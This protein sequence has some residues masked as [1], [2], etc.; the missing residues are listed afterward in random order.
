M[1]EVHEGCL[2][3]VLILLSK[4]RSSSWLLHRDSTEYRGSHRFAEMMESV[5][6]PQERQRVMSH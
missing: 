6:T 1:V 2:Y 5:G 3:V 4:Q